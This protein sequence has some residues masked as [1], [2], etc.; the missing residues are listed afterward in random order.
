MTLTYIG[1]GKHITGIPAR[2]LTADDISRIAGDLAMPESELIEL[3][4][5]RGI[6]SRPV[7]KASK[8][9]EPKETAPIADNEEGKE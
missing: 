1:N 2:D 3:L 4:I 9:T 7:T 6:Y 5:S 8:K